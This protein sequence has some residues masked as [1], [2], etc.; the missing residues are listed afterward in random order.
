V[1]QIDLP[2][3]GLSELAA[4][5]RE[6]ISSLPYGPERHIMLKAIWQSDDVAKLEEWASSLRLQPPK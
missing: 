1:Q 5:I 3:Q 2:L 4:D 6:K